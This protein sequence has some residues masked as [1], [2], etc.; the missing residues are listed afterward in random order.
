MV[1][2]IPVY[3]IEGKEVESLELDA[4][5][6]NGKVNRGLLHQVV[7]SYMANRRRGTASTKS[8]G[9]VS[10]GGRKPWA[11]KG[12]GRARAGSIRSPIFRGGGV[13]FGPHPRSYRKGIM[14]KMKRAALIHAINAKLLSGELKL[15]DEIKLAHPKTKDFVSVLRL[16]GIDSKK[17]LVS[18]ESLDEALLKAAHNVKYVRIVSQGQLNAYDILKYDILL[19][20]KE[21]FLKLSERLEK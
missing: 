14:K 15:V 3:N 13:V 9:E 21:S 10:G 8:R 2:S 20:S 5:L 16:L 11:Q 1:K 6:F 7:V 12:T 19:F 17:C 4:S 18:S